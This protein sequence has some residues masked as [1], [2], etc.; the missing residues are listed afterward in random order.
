MK[1]KIIAILVLMLL[2]ANMFSQIS[3]K[4]FEVV[5]GEKQTLFGAN[6]YWEDSNIGTISDLDGNFKIEKIK[7]TNKLIVSYIGYN[8]D[9]IEIVDKHKYVEVVMVAGQMLSEVTIR[10]RAPSSQYSRLSVGNVQDISG[11][12]LCKAACCNLSESFET[13]ASVDAGSCD[14]ATGSKQ[15]KLLGL[16]GKYVQ[17]LTENIPNLYGISQPYAL[18]YIPGPWMTSMQ[19]SKGT[20]N[21]INGY[22]AVTGQINVEYKKPKQSDKLS[23]NLMTSSHGNVEGNIDA[24]IMINDKLSTMIFAHAQTRYLKMDSDNDNFYDSPNITQ[25]NFFNRWDYFGKNLTFRAGIKYIDETRRNGQIS[26]DHET[27]DHSQPGLYSIKIHS[28]RGEA[29]AKCGYVFPEKDYQSIAV[30]TNFVGH[31]QDSYYG[32][33]IF[34]ATQYSFYG[35]VIWQSAFDK[36]EKHIYSTGVNFK[37]ENLDQLLDL[38]G[39]TD[40][41]LDSDT[42][43]A[44]SNLKNKDIEI[45]PGAFFQYTGHFGS[46]NMIFGIR[47][48]YHNQYGFLLTPRLNLKYD[49]NEFLTLRASAGRAYRKANVMGENSFLLASS[50]KI[51]IFN[52]LDMEEAWNYGA[53]F[54]ARIPISDRFMNINVEYYRT[55]FVRQIVAD[56]ETPGLVE[57][58]NLEG[59]SLSNTYQIEASYEILK[60]WDMTAAFR[61]NDVRQTIDGQLVESPLMSRFKGLL[62]TSYRTKLDKWQFDFTAQFNGPGRIPSTA[63]NPEEYQRD[64]KFKAYTICNA[65]VTKFF[66]RWNIYIGVENIFNFKQKDPIIAVT[67]PYSKYF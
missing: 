5:D 43:L 9:T 10:D 18:G 13:N 46:F 2:S 53:T 8:T 7:S 26:E 49:I 48:D 64:D 27:Y 61:Y 55:D 35:N 38:D 25:Y 59:K 14:A 56:F 20:S 24:P 62:T 17:F 33:N 54:S 31:H 50:R 60:G 28:Q 39:D 3:G 16:A 12:E 30:I 66:K 23:L 63:T 29:F 57:F 4:V 15:I 37:Y 11:K 47:G 36:N 51:V 19:I 22:D 65:Q 67:Q 58:Y 42:D 52:D 44:I 41:D 34:N 21:V 6:I 45:V 40:S 1:S 32:H